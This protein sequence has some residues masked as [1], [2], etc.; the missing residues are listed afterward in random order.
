MLNQTGIV[1]QFKLTGVGHSMVPWVSCTEKLIDK[2]VLTKSM[3]FGLSNGLVVCYDLGTTKA[4]QTWTIYPKGS[5][6]GVENLCVFN[7]AGKKNEDLIVGRND[8]SI[9]VY[10]NMAPKGAQMPLFE[11]RGSISME[12]TITNIGAQYFGKSQR[13][14]L[15]VTTYSGKIFGVF[16]ETEEGLEEMAQMVSKK[17]DQKKV[18]TSLQTNIQ[19]LEQEVEQEFNK[20]VQQDDVNGN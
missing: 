16:D 4:T 17:H 7:F 1:Y 11:I 18:V 14:E 9:E 3:L 5:K 12:E 10:I 20:Q 8:G 2:S 15:I 19:R 6:A 13:P